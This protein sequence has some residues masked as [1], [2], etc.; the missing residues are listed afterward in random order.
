MKYVSLGD[1]PSHTDENVSCPEC[2]CKARRA[3]SRRSTHE[4]VRELISR[5]ISFS[6]GDFKFTR[7]YGVRKTQ[8]DFLSD[9]KTRDQ[10]R[11]MSSQ[12][13][14]APLIV[15]ARRST[16]Q[17]HAIFCFINHLGNLPLDDEIRGVN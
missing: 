16:R 6:E 10:S 4:Q 5:N 7:S 1:Y 17:Q 8:P 14:A 3:I 9:M 12:S 15:Q 2:E 13:Q 11:S